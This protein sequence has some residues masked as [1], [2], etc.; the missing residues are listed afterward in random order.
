LQAETLS[1]GRRDVPS[2]FTISTAGPG[3]RDVSGSG[4]PAAP[5]R[6]RTAPVCRRRPSSPRPSSPSRPPE[7]DGAWSSPNAAQAM[8]AWAGWADGW[9]AGADD[10][11]AGAP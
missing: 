5:R 3:R 10:W 7:P 6:S 9:S 2:P 1:G 4:I 11:N 8:D